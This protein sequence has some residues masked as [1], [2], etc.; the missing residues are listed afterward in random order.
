MKRKIPYL[1]AVFLLPLFSQQTC[2]STKKTISP[3][4]EDDHRKAVEKFEPNIDLT[5]LFSTEDA[6][7]KLDEVCMQ[8]ANMKPED[9]RIKELMGHVFGTQYGP[10]PE[11]PIK[12]LVGL[13]KKTSEPI[14]TSS[15]KMWKNTFK[16]LVG[17]RY[18]LMEKGALCKSIT[19]PV[20]RLEYL[21]KMQVVQLITEL[22]PETLETFART[23]LK[24]ADKDEIPVNLI[25]AYEKQQE[26]E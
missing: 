25:D 14:P 18:E 20:R 10:L 6:L 9:V 19:S 24:L 21:L 7:K 12:K 15:D 26:K 1:L 2:T 13:K 23:A 22:T 8:K 17:E 5:T 11:D 16:I 4:S 3:F